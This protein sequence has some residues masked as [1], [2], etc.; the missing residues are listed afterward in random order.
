DRDDG[1]GVAC[2]RARVWVAYEESG[3]AVDAGGVTVCGLAGMVSFDA[4]PDAAGV[5]RMAEAL[6]HR[7]PDDHGS[8]LAEHVALAHL[9]LSIIDLSPRG[10]QPMAGLDGR[11]QLVYN[12]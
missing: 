4:P 5:L 11:V 9:R 6:Q 3:D 1:Y 7:G 10:H 12:G 2:D 8:Y